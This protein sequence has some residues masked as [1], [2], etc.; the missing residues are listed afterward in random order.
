MADIYILLLP[1]RSRIYRMESIVKVKVCCIYWRDYFI[2]ILYI[3]LISLQCEKCGQD[4]QQRDEANAGLTKLPNE[5]SNDCYDLKNYI[6]DI[7][8]VLIS[9]A[10]FG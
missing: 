1:G 5:V 2:F 9:F 3:I 8:L 4:V 10:D 7:L 6:R